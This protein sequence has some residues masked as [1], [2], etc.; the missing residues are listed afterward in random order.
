LRESRDC[1]APT[2]LG[3]G[4]GQGAR[5]GARGGPGGGRGRA[6]S[7]YAGRGRVRRWGMAPARAGR[8]AFDDAG[9]G[10]KALVWRRAG[11]AVAQR[12]PRPG[13]PCV[14]D[15]KLSS[16]GDRNPAA[17]PTT[18]SAG[19]LC[20]SPISF[21]S[22]NVG[23]LTARPPQTQRTSRKG[24]VL[25]GPGARPG[26]PSTGAQL[27]RPRQTR[28]AGSCPPPAPGAPRYCDAE[29]GASVL[30][31]QTPCQLLCCCDPRPTRKQRAESTDDGPSA[32]A[33][34][35][36][37]LCTCEATNKSVAA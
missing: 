15:P 34:A 17:E 21:R 32:G 11:V 4:G 6:G 9:R 12:R 22:S 20:F 23:M 13:W 1:S 5:G 3:C 24:F 33:A 10:C 26:A 19:V 25:A 27:S 37:S 8:R 36:L 16:A 2:T 14:A 28:R 7:R 30:W 35:A 18:I 29:P 31:A